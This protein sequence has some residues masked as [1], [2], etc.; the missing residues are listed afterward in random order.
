[1][2]IFP[3]MLLEK[4]ARWS[5]ATFLAGLLLALA[6]FLWILEPFLVTLTIAATIAVLLIPV[7]EWLSRVLGGRRN[8][9]AWICALGS[10]ILVLA[11][12]TYLLIRVIV[13]AVPAISNFASTLGE[14]GLAQWLQNEAPQPVRLAYAR[15]L[16]MGLGDQLREVLGKFA[17]WLGG[18]VAALPSFIGLMVTDGLVLIVTLVWFFAAGPFIVRRIIESVPMEPR[19]TEDLFR[20][21]RAGVR[22]IM[23]ASL[24]T[25][26]IQGVLGFGAF[27][28]LRIPYALLLAALMAFF[29]FVFSLVP[30]LGSGMV[31]VPAAIWLAV[32]GRLFAG[33]FLF[34]YGFLVLGS[35]DNVVKP[36][37]TK[38][39]LRLPPALVFVTVFGGLY[40]FGPVGALIGPLIAALM[41]AFLRIW[42]EDFLR[43]PPMSESGDERLEPHLPPSPYDERDGQLIDTEGQRR[44]D[45]EPKKK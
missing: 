16:E 27:W 43:L 12:I 11:P 38:D 28:I 36:F 41:G 33:I 40:A 5:N 31:W 44:K 2:R 25:A 8:L 20:T 9:A 23:L 21:M 14:G 26:G 22:T 32:T 35:V 15:V 30:V 18:F 42:R 6:L 7:Q 13:E 37:F 29:S 17:S 10:V 45:E 39:A 19:Y 1:M 3:A 24:L 34:L 4:R